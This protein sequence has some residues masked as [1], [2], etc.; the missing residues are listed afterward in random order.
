VGS[1]VTLLKNDKPVLC[2]PNS[3]MFVAVF[4]AFI[5]FSKQLMYSLETLLNS[6]HESTFIAGF[7]HEIKK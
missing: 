4:E 6:L 3:L 7:E 5:T 2:L 1:T